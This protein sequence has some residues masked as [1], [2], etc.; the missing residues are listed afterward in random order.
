MF[1]VV[2]GVLIL[3]FGVSMVGN[4]GSLTDRMFERTASRVDPGMAT[5]NTF[6]IVG[7][8]VIFIGIFWVATGVSEII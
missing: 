2:G 7:V 4:L 8:I 1:G 3:S 6:R 5:P